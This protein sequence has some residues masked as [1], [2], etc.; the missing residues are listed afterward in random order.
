[1]IAWNER[2]NETAVFLVS[3]ILFPLENEYLIY[4]QINFVQAGYPWSKLKHLALTNE[5]FVG[6]PDLTGDF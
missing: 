6:L 3:K 5:D 2:L 4:V 1:M